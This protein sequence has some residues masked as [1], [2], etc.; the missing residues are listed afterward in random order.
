MV[1]LRIAVHAIKV[2]KG[3]LSLLKRHAR[4]R[5]G[6]PF[7]LAKGRSI[8]LVFVRLMEL[9]PGRLFAMEPMML[10]GLQ[11]VEL[12]RKLG[13]DKLVGAR[14]DPVFVICVIL[15]GG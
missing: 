11:S 1:I 7:V 9:Q 4:P 2:T 8:G 14:P 15:S 3:G 13:F 6:W 10:P 12:V 5:S